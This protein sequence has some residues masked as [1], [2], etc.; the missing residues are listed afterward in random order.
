MKASG[1][2]ALL[3]SC[4]AQGLLVTAAMTPIAPA[5]AD[6]NATATPIKHVI[7]LIGENRTFDNIYATYQPKKGQSVGNLLSRG[8]I[9]ES[10]IPGPNFVQSLQYQANPPYTSY[11]IDSRTLSAGKTPYQPGDATRN[12]TPPMCRRRRVRS[13]KGKGPSTRRCRTRSCRRSSHP[14]RKTT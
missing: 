2:R 9:Y 14:L 7:I 13:A 3:L 4:A 8:I 10:G 1:L 5:I 12:P 6:D 11:F